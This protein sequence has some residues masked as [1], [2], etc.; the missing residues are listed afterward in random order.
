MGVDYQVWLIP[1]DRA[2]RPSADKVANLA[3]ALRDG[4]W[5]PP[6]SAEGQRSEILELLPGGDLMRRKPAQVHS[7][8]SEPFT[9]PWIE[10]HSQHE[11]VLNWSVNDQR[12]AGVQYPF[13]FDPF[14]DP[15]MP[16]YFY[17][18]LILGHDFFY[19]TGET[20]MPIDEHATQCQCGEQLSFWTG[21]AHGAPS[22]RIF[23][24][25]PKCSQE[26]DPSGV[27]CDI[28]DGWTGKGAPLPGGLTFRFGLVVNCHKYF[29]KEEEAARR[30]RLRPEFLDLWRMH[31]GVPFEQIETWD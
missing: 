6:A 2:F 12:A 25:C 14:P 9:A 15:R 29:P 4:G 22:Q 17:V 23:S 28:L 27:S 26:F 30:F 20:V 16:P 13:S 5:V 1:E 3:N 19:Y 8:T 11:L 24:R 21:S 7:F 31:V 10:F 18:Y